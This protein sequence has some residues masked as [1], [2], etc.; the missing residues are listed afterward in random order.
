VP[1]RRPPP[2]AWPHWQGSIPARSLADRKRYRGWRA[3]RRPAKSRYGWTAVELDYSAR[4]QQGTCDRT[5]IHSGCLRCRAV[6]RPSWQ[7]VGRGVMR[8]ST[9]PQEPFGIVTAMRLQSL[10]LSETPQASSSTGECLIEQC[11]LPRCY[12][13]AGAQTG[14]VR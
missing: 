6:L 4:R 14:G 10:R 11:C 1:L 13:P 2:R 3:A 9:I 5:A 8:W 7:A 12:S